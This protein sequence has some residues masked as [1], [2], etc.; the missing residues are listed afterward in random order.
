MREKRIERM[1]SGD[2]GLKLEIVLITY[3]RG[4]G[5]GM[6]W[7]KMTPR[8]RFFALKHEWGQKSTNEF[9]RGDVCVESV[10]GED[11]VGTRAS[12]KSC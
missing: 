6:D 9:K 4:G 10:L 1:H 11:G 7:C 2:L 5:R 3:V 8:F 12:G